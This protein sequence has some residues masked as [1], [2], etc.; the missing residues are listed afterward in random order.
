MLIANIFS[1]ERP[2][3]Q[4]L[5]SDEIEG[6]VSFTVMAAKPTKMAPHPPGEDHRAHEE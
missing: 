2:P 3:Q 5:Q 6:M 4:S 1:S